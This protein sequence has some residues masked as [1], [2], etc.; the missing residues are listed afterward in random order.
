MGE[1][2]RLGTG[3]EEWG[4][5]WM[6]EIAKEVLARSNKWIRCLRN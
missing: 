2:G 5:G 3:G 4:V 6:E 1:A